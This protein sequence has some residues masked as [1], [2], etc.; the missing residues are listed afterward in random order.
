MMLN[1]HFI[2]GEYSENRLQ[3]NCRKEH[4]PSID[5]M[6]LFLQKCKE[7]FD[8]PEKFLGGM[9]DWVCNESKVAPY[10]FRTKNTD[11]D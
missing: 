9:F 1:E 10:L 2:H 7:A 8:N 6:E 4:L 3:Y 11:N 5:K